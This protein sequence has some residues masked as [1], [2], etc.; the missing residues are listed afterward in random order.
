[1]G[2]TLKEVKDTVKVSGLVIAMNHANLE[3]NRLHCTP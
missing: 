2:V 3:E 1:M